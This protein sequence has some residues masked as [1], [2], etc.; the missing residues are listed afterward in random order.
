MKFIRPIVIQDATLVSSNVPEADHPTYSPI[1][2][3]LLGEYVIVVSTNVHKIYKSLQG[4]SSVATMTIAAPCV[5][6]W[7]LHGLTAG[8][9]IVFS[10]TGALPTGLV[11]GTVYYVLAPLS[12]TFNVSATVGGAAITTT[13]TQSGVHTVIGNPNLGFSVL[14]PLRW[15][16]YGSTNR[17]KLHDQSVQSQTIN[18][19]IIQ[20]SYR[21]VGRCNSVA[22]L[23]V[24]AATV[25]VVM[26]DDIDGVVY[27][28]TEQLV[29][30]SGVQDFYAYMSE[31]IVRYTDF[32]LTDLP[33]YANALITVTITGS[34]DIGCGG[35]IL[36]NAKDIGHTQ[37]GAQV[38]ITDYS[39]K[40]QDD[41]GNYTVVERAF[42][43]TGEFSVAVNSGLVDQLQVMLASLRAT[44]VVYVGAD[45]YRSTLIYGFYSD[46]NI[47][48]SYPTMS[49][50]AITIQGLT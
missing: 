31:P 26:T 45:N 44:P 38:G 20:N 12:G 1:T 35:L 15:V 36:G 50:C 37:F 27:T 32:V 39:V 23:N 17:W 41:F 10:T 8:T 9:P 5:V 48:I 6:A 13:G 33:M 40:T 16:D 49:M 18:P 19:D 43:K 14:D 7:A 4:T 11:A 28:H 3:Y 2:S 46:F 34:G 30:N 29:S 21:V 24:A 22:L 42:R 47:V 25:Q